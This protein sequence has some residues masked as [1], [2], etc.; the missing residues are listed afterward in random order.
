MFTL[1]E[2]KH[3][4]ILIAAILALSGCG[5]GGGSSG[6]SA[7]PI[8]NATALQVYPGQ[9]I[10]ACSDALGNSVMP[11]TLMAIGG[12]PGS[13]GYYWTL[14][15][16]QN[17]PTGMTIAVDS[18]TGILT[19]TIPNNFTAG[20]Y[21]I[22]VQ[23]SDGITTFSGSVTVA[24]N[25]GTI[26]P[27]NGWYA[28]HVSGGGPYTNCP[29]R[30]SSAETTSYNTMAPI[31]WPTFPSVYANMHYGVNVFAAGITQPNW[32]LASGQLPPGL[33]INP[34]NGTIY[35]TVTAGTPAS[36]YHFNVTDNNST[37][38]GYPDGASYTINTN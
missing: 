12:N 36:N 11:Q 1:K 27:A 26:A 20:N 32:A 37:A 35:G 8:S 22:N 16:S 28:V 30:Y 29:G 34:S 31:S 4:T 10:Y 33:Q 21:S 7:G 24:V 23:V 15:S 14:S 25:N 13:S 2:F 3:L 18:N 9:S 19:G 38:S 17:I 6:A 5:G